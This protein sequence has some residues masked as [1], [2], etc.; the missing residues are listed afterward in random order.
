[1]GNFAFDDCSP[2]REKPA[3]GECARECI[4]HVYTDC[5]E[6]FVRE[7]VLEGGKLGMGLDK[8]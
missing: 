4:F 2:E 7:V 8:G 6:T 5:Y 3:G 1:M